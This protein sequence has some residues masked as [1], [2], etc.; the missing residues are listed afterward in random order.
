MAESKIPVDLF[1]PGQV[2]A[3]LGFMELS[4][5]LLGDAEAGFD[6]SDKAKAE[7]YLSAAGKKNPFEAV[8]DFIKVATVKPV[9]PAGVDGPWPQDTVETE[10]FPAPLSE[11]M[12]STGKK[13]TASAL[14]I[15][16]ENER[17][18]FNVSNWL[19]GDKREALKLFAGQQVAAKLMTNAL[20]GDS[21]KKGTIG[22]RQL[23]PKP[24]NPFE[25]GP[26]GGRFGYDSR[27]AWDA[28]NT[29]SSLDE[30]GATLLVS[31]V[32][33]ALGAIG[34]EHTRPEFLSTYEIRYVV[35][36]GKIPASLA[37]A[38]FTQPRGLVPCGHFRCFRSH[39]GD[40]KQY[41]KCFPANEELSK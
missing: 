20:C 30:Q 6:W 28:I 27:G 33:E 18:N 29:G 8:L 4:D 39:L 37:R 5:V 7:F 34:L 3:C 23:A 24:D 19:E 40:D 36:Q 1:N 16:L 22:V 38:V 13:L 21:T 32:V 17:R 2:F 12:D 14:P 11:L 41:K 35:W 9:R 10:E 26:V 25:A 15:S 31:P